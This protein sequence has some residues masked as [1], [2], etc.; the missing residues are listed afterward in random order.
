MTKI[1]VPLTPVSASR[2]RVTRYGTYYGKKHSQ[3]VKDVQ[4]LFDTKVLIAPDEPKTCPVS[5]SIDFYIPI[6]KST[7]KRQRE[8]LD[9][10]YHS[11]KPDIDNLCKLAIDEILSSQYK[12]SILVKPRYLKDD[13]QIVKLQATKSWT[14]ETTGWVDINIEYFENVLY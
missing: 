10:L 3:F 12:K 2:P 13:T 6:P 7:S 1:S 4:A 11:K 5:V 8:R 9:S 14:T